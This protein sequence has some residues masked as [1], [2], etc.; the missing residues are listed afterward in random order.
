MIRPERLVDLF[1]SLVRIDGVSGREDAVAAAVVARL[2]ALG[3]PCHTD[4]AGDSFGGNSGN[5]LARLPGTTDAPA[6]LLCAHMD[7]VLP[8]HGL[9]VTRNAD[10]ITTDGT[11]ILGADDR[12]GIAI[13]LEILEALID[14]RAAHGPIEVLFSVAEESGMH[15]ARAVDTSSLESSMGFVFDNSATCGSFVI[16][17]P[18]AVAF[19]VFVRGRAA[20]AAVAPENGVHAIQ[21]AS[22]AIARLP[23]GRHGETGM[24]NIGTIRGGTA[25]NVVPDEVQ[26]TGETRSPD[27][28]SLHAQMVLVKE[29]FGQVAGEMGGQ[30]EIEWTHKYGGFALAP[31]EPVVVAA[32]QGISAA[33]H[34]P[35]PIRY[36]GGSDA[37]VLNQRGIPTVN[38]GI[39]TLNVHS[40]QEAMPTLSLIHGAEIG[41]GIVREMVH[42][43]RA[44]QR[45]THEVSP[46]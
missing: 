10:R 11:T 8:T 13:I 24:L 20:H 37:N 7:T 33:G 21:I 12:A 3:V 28:G 29:A 31:S 27:P 43:G 14:G 22:Q 45:R 42:G 44:V 17:A 46:R 26:V 40:K 35:R 41:L 23:L 2:T 34:V 25:I 32:V 18:A 30:V 16:E 15:G 1:L 19:T 9:K 6:I 39:G 36:P 4:R 5:V 38:L